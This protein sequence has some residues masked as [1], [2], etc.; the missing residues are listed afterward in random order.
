[1]D[2]STAAALASHASHI[3]DWPEPEG[4]L[5]LLDLIGHATQ[6]QF[7]YRHEWR[8]GDPPRSAITLRRWINPTARLPEGRAAPA[9]E[10]SGL[11]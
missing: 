5:L 7:V 4:R 2:A 1:V 3:V 9:G 6:P 10:A 11:S 8:D